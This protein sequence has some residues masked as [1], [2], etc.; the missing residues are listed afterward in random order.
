MKKNLSLMTVLLAALVASSCA[1]TNKTEQKLEKEVK[2]VLAEKTKSI[3]ETIND[4]IKASNL[5]ADQKTKLLAL[6]EKSHA[7]HVALIDEIERT[8]VVLIQT[9]LAPNMSQKEFKI[10]KNKIRLLEKQR[11]E[12]GFA[13][14]IEARKI[15]APTASTQNNEV[16]KAVIENRLRG[17]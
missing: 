11:L 2:E 3:S 8:K 4:Q 14:A 13:T 5:S 10:L 17:F 7:K 15:I 16:Y 1:H 12:N 9:V 6:E